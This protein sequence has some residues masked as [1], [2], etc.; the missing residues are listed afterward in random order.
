MD[1]PIAPVAHPDAPRERRLSYKHT[2]DTGFDSFRRSLSNP[3]S[4]NAES[5]IHYKPYVPQV[6]VENHDLEANEMDAARQNLR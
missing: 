3:S 4:P 6:V 5:T 1:D 2:R